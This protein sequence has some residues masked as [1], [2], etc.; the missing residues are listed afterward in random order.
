MAVTRDGYYS[1]NARF[2]AAKISGQVV[3]YMSK[4][5]EK[6]RNQPLINTKNALT[7]LYNALCAVT[8]ATINF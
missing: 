3:L 1:N 7:R 6:P 8:A 4:F 5:C 2:V